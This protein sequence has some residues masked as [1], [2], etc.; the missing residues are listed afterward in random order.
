MLLDDVL[1]E[2]DAVR[3]DFL[4]R[5]IEGRQVLLTSCDA[6]AFHD[7]PGAIYEMEAGRLRAVKHED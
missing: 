3:R 1:S 6:A 5:K 2:L 4:L 7:T